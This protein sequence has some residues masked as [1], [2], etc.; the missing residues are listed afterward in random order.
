MR[1]QSGEDALQGTPRHES[2]FAWLASSFP[3]MMQ[4]KVENCIN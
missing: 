3:G 1:V 4:E 2:L